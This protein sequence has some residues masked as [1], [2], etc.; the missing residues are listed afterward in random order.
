MLRMAPN[1][2]NSQKQPKP[3]LSTEIYKNKLKCKL[4]LKNY[5][6]SYSSSRGRKLEVRGNLLTNHILLDSR[7]LF[8]F[9]SV[10][11]EQVYAFEHAQ[12]S[13]MPNPQIKR[14]LSLWSPFGIVKQEDQPTSY[15]PV[16]TARFENPKP[17][18]PRIGLPKK[19]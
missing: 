2:G 16:D 19:S 7:I 18:R 15:F 5:F 4:F 12:K 11:D 3:L 8:G 10:L 17:T 1:A 13:K 9:L 14:L 6:F